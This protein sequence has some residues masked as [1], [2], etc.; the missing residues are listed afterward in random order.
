MT[1][2]FDIPDDLFS[3]FDR[4]E[5]AV[6]DNDLA[7]LDEMFAAGPGTMRGDGAGLLVG[8]DTISAF[9]G[10]RGGVPPREIERIEY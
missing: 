1:A 6:L 7:V 10:V 3:A 2:V 9:R 8:H 5:R 4:Y